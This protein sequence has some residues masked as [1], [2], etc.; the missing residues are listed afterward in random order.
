MGASI[1]DMEQIKSFFTRKL[2]RLFFNF[3]YKKK[4]PRMVKYWRWGNAAKAR[5][6]EQKDGSFGM[7]IEGEDEIYPGF[8]RGH[9][10]M[11]PLQ[12]LKTTLKNRLFNEVFAELAKMVDGM[13]YDIVPRE[14]MVAPVREIYDMFE[15]LEHMEVVEDMKL[16][17]KLI[18]TILCFFLQEDDAYRMR[19]QYFLSNI[20]QK[21]VALSEADKY[22]ARGKYWKVDY[23]KHEY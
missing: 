4:Q 1:P 18:R 3:L 15:K 14:R 11:G 20:N 6:L 9:V 22:Y 2:I 8:P 23:D 13:K 7:Q 16:R 21:K 10:L 12:E 17:M 5:V 19:A